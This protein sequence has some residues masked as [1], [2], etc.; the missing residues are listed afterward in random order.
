MLLTLAEMLANRAAKVTDD[1]AQLTITAFSSEESLI[2]VLRTR[3]SL[4]KA[5]AVH[6]GCTI[7]E[8]PI[9]RVYLKPNGGIIVGS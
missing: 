5:R 7:E 4:A 1:T 6:P 8:V 2:L 3:K 9:H